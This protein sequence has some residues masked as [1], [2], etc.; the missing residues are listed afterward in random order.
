MSSNITHIRLSLTQNEG[1]LSDSERSQ[2]RIKWIESILPKFTNLK[3]LDLSDNEIGVEEM[4]ALNPALQ[5]LTG[6]TSLD[7]SDNVIGVEGMIALA[8]T[9]QQLTVL[10]HSISQGIK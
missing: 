2:R 1:R 4:G 10:L 6:L 7:L 5:Q 3:T 8:P 9:L